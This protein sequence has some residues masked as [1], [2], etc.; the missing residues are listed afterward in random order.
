MKRIA[1]PVL[2]LAL[3]TGLAACGSS[4]KPGTGQTA[5]G[6]GCPPATGKA[7]SY[8]GRF[9]GQV[10]MDQSEH[11]LRVTRDGRPVSGAKV[12]VNTAM[13][14]MRSM[15]YTA[16]GKELGPG[17]YGVRIKFG[18]AGTYRGS[19]VTGKGGGEASIPLSVKVASKGKMSHDMKSHGK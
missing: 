6:K 2:A 19:L 3:G 17:R 1:V 16:S 15:H 18:M 14:G 5:Q 4:D 12:C 11:V 9:E 8:S 7:G 10:S 13:A